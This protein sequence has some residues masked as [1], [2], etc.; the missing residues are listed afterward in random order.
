ML[1]HSATATNSTSRFMP[2]NNQGFVQRPGLSPAQ[3]SS[4]TQSPA[5][6]PAQPAPP[7]PPPTVQTADTSKVSGMWNADT[8][9]IFVVIGSFLFHL[10]VKDSARL[11]IMFMLNKLF[12]LYSGFEEHFLH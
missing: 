11:I 4:P 8:V 6:A 12:F 7:A 2:S 1:P 10:P 5:Q 3:P 9:L